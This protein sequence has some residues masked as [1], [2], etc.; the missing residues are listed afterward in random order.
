MVNHRRAKRSTLTATNMPDALKVQPLRSEHPE[1]PVSTTAT[2]FSPA[3]G[4]S[5]TGDPVS[6]GGI[7]SVE[8]VV[9][10]GMSVNLSS[11][12]PGFPSIDPK[13]W[14]GDQNGVPEVVPAAWWEVLA[15]IVSFWPKTRPRTNVSAGAPGKLWSTAPFRG[16]MTHH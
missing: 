3:L 1:Q 11:G 8:C 10:G 12:P 5:Y 4:T 9:C 14:S 16:F 15:T 13:L 7:C 6:L 2:G